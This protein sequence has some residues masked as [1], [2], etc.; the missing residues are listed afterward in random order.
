MQSMLF[1]MLGGVWVLLLI[2]IGILRDIAKNTEPP[3][4]DTVAAF[5]KLDVKPGDVV[6]FRLSD[7]L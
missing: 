5:T 7:S 6:L 3:P 1:V 4:D 2:G